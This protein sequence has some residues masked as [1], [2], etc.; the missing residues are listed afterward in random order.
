MDLEQLCKIIN[1]EAK[2]DIL[3]K[4]LASDLGLCSYDMMVLI[5]EIEDS[6]GYEID[7][8]LIKKDMTIAEVL[9]IINKKEM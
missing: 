7:T 5:V 9:D 4:H 3:Q 8:S 1:V 2:E 6:C